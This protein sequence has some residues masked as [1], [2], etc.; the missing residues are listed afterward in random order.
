MTGSDSRPAPNTAT[1][2][3]PGHVD[4]ITVA[5]WLTEPDSV[6]VIDVRSS[7]E[8]GSAHIPGSY[9]VPLDLLG[10]HAEQFPASRFFAGLP[11]QRT[12][13]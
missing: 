11:P 12:A 9:N 3:R 7:A 6:T 1:A 13:A 4:A 5:G 8:F 10:E 2:A